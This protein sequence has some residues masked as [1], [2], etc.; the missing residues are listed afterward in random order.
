M[1]LFTDLIPSLDD[2]YLA[3]W[4]VI[5]IVAIYFVVQQL[6]FFWLTLKMLWLNVKKGWKWAL[7]KLGIPQDI[8]TIKFNQFKKWFKE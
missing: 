4:N 7:H 2:Q 8:L 3:G 6:L 5:F 1:L